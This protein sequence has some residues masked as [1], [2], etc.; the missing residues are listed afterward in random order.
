MQIGRLVALAADLRLTTERLVIRRVAE[1]DVATAIAHEEDRRIMRW[2]RDA[3]PRDE[4]AARVVSETKAA[5]ALRCM[6]FMCLS[7]FC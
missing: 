1:R 3:L 2:I 4:I 7:P 6:V 5:R